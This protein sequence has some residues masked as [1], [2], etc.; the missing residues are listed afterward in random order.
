MGLGSAV[1]A[2]NLRLARPDLTRRSLSIANNEWHSGTPCHMLWCVPFAP[3]TLFIPSSVLSLFSVYIPGFI[4]LLLWFGLVYIPSFPFCYAGFALSFT[5]RYHPHVFH[6][7]R[8]LLLQPI[9]SCL[10]REDI[11]LMFSLYFVHE[12]RLSPQA[13]TFDLKN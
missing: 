13:Q 9:S 6:T 5:H 4:P 12:S 8:V 3:A 2:R 7:S 10:F 11:I 1:C